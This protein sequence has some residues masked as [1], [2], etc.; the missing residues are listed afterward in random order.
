[1]PAKKKPLI[2][3]VLCDWEPPQDLTRGKQVE[4]LREHWRKREITFP[5]Y[6]GEYDPNTLEFQMQTGTSIISILWTELDQVTAPA[7]K[8]KAEYD[9]WLFEKQQTDPWES[10]A[11]EDLQRQLD[12]TT[13]FKVGRGLA[14]ALFHMSKPYFD[15]A[16]EVVVHAVQRAKSV[17]AGT[18]CFTP[19]T[20]AGPEADRE[21]LEA[22]RRG[23]VYN[24]V[25]PTPAPAEPAPQ[26]V[27]ASAPVPPAPA[28][29][30]PAAPVAPTP[31]ERAPEEDAPMYGHKPLPATE[32]AEMQPILTAPQVEAIAK[33]IDAGLPKAA[34]AETY[35]ITEAQLDEALKFL[36]PA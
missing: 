8:E 33:A 5:W 15:S 16:D 21:W 6:Q 10:Y 18:A 11:Q 13:K 2:Y 25:D 24:P 27:T 28:V 30:A 7:M 34:L 12:M 9:A 22:K 31:V 4:L 1:M 35:G 17:E 32:T 23:E 3:C 26:P 20:G 36:D 14:I 29:P 19:G